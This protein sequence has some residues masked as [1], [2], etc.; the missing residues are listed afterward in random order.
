MEGLYISSRQAGKHCEVLLTNLSQPIWKQ[1]SI[2]DHRS[3]LAMHD[4]MHSRLGLT[5]RVSSMR[6]LFGLGLE[7]RLGIL[8]RSQVSFP[9]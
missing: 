3:V 8:L 6:G 5:A 4:V 2:I 7:I 1:T 9:I